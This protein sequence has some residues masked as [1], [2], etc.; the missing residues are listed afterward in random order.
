MSE[1]VR[2][3]SGASTCPV[4]NPSREVIAAAILLVAEFRRS[5]KTFHFTARNKELLSECHIEQSIFCVAPEDYKSY[6]E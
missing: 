4:V 2:E 1:A 5:F 6:L 3:V